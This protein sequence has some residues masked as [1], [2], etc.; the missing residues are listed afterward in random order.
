MMVKNALRLIQ[1]AERARQERIYFYERNQKFQRSKAL[2]SKLL[3]ENAVNKSTNI[4]P[5]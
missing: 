4:L 2:V 1:I 3:L 5:F